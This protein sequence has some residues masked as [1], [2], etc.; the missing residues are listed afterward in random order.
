MTMLRRTG[1]ASPLYQPPP[2]PQARPLVR[3]P[4]YACNR[5]IVAVPKENPVRSEP[6]RRLVAAMPCKACGIHGFS[7]AAHVP[8]D[9]RGIKQD[10]RQTFALCCTRP[11]E[12]GCHVRYDRWIMFPRAEAVEQGLRWAAETR[13]EID[14]AGQW[15]AG[16]PRMCPPCTQDCNQ[17]RTC[18]ART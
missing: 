8:P 1:F 9:G 14:E 3:R 12:D 5:V 2:A 11:G 13:Q 7:Q 15:P 10:D 16:L 17:G 18:P 6:Y 4:S